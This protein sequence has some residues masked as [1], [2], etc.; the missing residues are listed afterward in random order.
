MALLYL[1]RHGEPSGTWGQADPDPGLTDLGRKQA[2]G[3]AERLQKTP[4]KLIVSSPLKRA[5]ETAIPLA[6]AMS[7][8]P[9]IAEPVAEIPTPASIA[10]E[11]RADWLRSLMAGEWHAAEPPLQTWRTGVVTYLTGL[12]EDTA[13]FSHFVAINVALGAAIGDDRVVCFKPAHAS[14]TVLETKGRVISL[15][16]LGE[17][18]DTVIR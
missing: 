18:A 8:E 1:I 6:R 3:A 4:P 12:S 7:L 2:E 16:E 15:V 17:T 14:I 13:V 5:R 11:K 10:F 9:K